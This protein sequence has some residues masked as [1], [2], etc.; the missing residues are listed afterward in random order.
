VE[1]LRGG[2]HGQRLD[3]RYEDAIQVEPTTRLRC[4]V[5][6]CRVS[7]ERLDDSPQIGERSLEIREGSLRLS[8]DAIRQG[9]ETRRHGGVQAADAGAD[10]GREHVRCEVGTM[11]C[12]GKLVQEDGL[13]ID[14]DALEGGPGLPLLL[15]GDAGLE[16]GLLERLLNGAEVSIGL[17]P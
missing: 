16:P 12:D 6:N 9:I 1:A 13:R 11:S 7:Q 3:P 4:D 14:R 17:G 2:R 5:G 8:L 15:T 10:G